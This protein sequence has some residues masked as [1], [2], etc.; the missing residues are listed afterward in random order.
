MER[1]RSD[2]THETP[3]IT[4][5][6]LA[7]HQFAYISTSIRRLWIINISI[8]QISNLSRCFTSCKTKY[9]STQEASVAQ[10]VK[11]SPAF[12]RKQN[13]YYFAANRLPQAS[14][15]SQ[16]NPVHILTLYCFRVNSSSF[17]LCLSFPF[18][19]YRQDFESVRATCTAH[20]TLSV[21]N[22]IMLSPPRR[23]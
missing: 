17:H 22:L 9:S 20:Q 1:R 14:N 23:L 3:Y 8:K 7:C 15:L 10:H 2:V 21:I 4:P 11:N 19:S 5:L 16:M 6:G 18:I 12:F 13:T